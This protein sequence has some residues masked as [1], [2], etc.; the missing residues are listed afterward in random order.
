MVE[1]SQPLSKLALVTLVL[2]VC[3]GLLKCFQL[4]LPPMMGYLLTV[5]MSGNGELAF[6]SGE[7]IG[8]R[9]PHSMKV[10]TEFHEDLNKVLQ[11]AFE[12][13]G[14]KRCGVL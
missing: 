14:R 4:S 7:G 9:L 8:K 11:P 10:L 12:C 6:Y 5:L 2:P 3:L 13:V 1:Y